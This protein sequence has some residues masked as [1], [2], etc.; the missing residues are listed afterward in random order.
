MRESKS[1]EEKRSEGKRE[2]W[3]ASKGNGQM[4]NARTG[5]YV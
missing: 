4:E 1:R 2:Q 3:I 5:G